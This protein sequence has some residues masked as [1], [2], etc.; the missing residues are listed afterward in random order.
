MNA[1]S[2]VTAALLVHLGWT[3]VQDILTGTDNFFQAF[4]PAADP[5]GLVEKLGERFEIMR[6]NIK[7]WSVGSPI[8]AAL[9]GLEALRT[10]HPF[11][12]DQVQGITVRLATDEANI[13]NNREIPGI[14]LQHMLAVM[15]LDK[16]ITFRSA[17]DTDRMKDAEV[18]RQRAKVQLIKDEE[19]QSL[20]PLRVAIVDV[21]LADGKRLNKRV[22]N[23]RGTPENPMTREEVVTK[24]KDLIAPVLGAAGTAKLIE[25]VMSFEGIADVREI[26]PLLQRA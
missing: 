18:L 14:C 3:G 24:A 11:T 25:R 13:V 22:D 1:R 5:A 9:D 2:G 20:M 4:E 10:E 8:Q 7:K 12:A 19:L 17:H 26:R 23:V 6:T 21:N 16:T 15:V